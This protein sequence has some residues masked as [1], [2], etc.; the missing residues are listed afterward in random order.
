MSFSE[1][2]LARGGRLTSTDKVLPH[3]FLGSLR[4]RHN[5]VA[6]KKNK[7]SHVVCIIDVPDIIVDKEGSYT[8]LN[9]QAADS[10]EQ[11]LSQHFEK[12]ID[13]IHAARL[14]GKDVLVHC[15]AGISRSATIV[16]AYLMTIMDYDFDKAMQIVRGARDYIYPNYGF[17]EQLKKYQT[18]D[19]KKKWYSLRRRYSNYCSIEDERF[20]QILL[21]S[22]WKQFE[23]AYSA[24]PVYWPMRRAVVKR[25][26]IAKTSIDDVDCYNLLSLHKKIPLTTGKTSRTTSASYYKKDSFIAN[27]RKTALILAG[28][29]VSLV[30][31]RICLMLCKTSVVP[32]Q[33]VAIIDVEHKLDVPPKYEEAIKSGSEHE[34]KLPSYEELQTTTIALP[35]TS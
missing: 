9:I 11:N 34:W 22:Y 12:C 15:Q 32:H 24:E 16:L 19:I 33:S 8:V 7:I 2:Y 27:L 35:N 1:R 4:D 21:S 26:N 29:A 30:L 10:I 25:Q 13:F 20:T 23:P 28:I 18:N 5:V 17:C 6:M 3:L 31:L 14:D